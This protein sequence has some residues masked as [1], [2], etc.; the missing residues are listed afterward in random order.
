MCQT[1]RNMSVCDN[2]GRLNNM[3]QVNRLPIL[4]VL[5]CTIL[6]KTPPAAG[7]QVQAFN[8]ML[9]FHILIRSSTLSVNE[10]KSILKAP[11][12]TKLTVDLTVK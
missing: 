4:H 6:Y 1:S 10:Y 3:G 12:V 11:I 8:Q 5:Y 2:L 7:I 9:I